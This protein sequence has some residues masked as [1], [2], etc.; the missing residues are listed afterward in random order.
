M[1][2]MNDWE[3]WDNEKVGECA[4]KFAQSLKA[5]SE[6]QV[7]LLTFSAALVLC[8]TVRET[9]A[10]QLKTEITGMTIEGVPAGNWRVTI[11]RI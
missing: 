3:T 7:R 9:N 11:E 8:R 4:K 2:D 10:D 5:I 6:K 1:S